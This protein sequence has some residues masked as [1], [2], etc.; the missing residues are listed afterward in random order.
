MRSG[1]DLLYRL[2]GG[3]AAFFLMMIAV[4][5]VAQIVGRAVGVT[6]DS[7]ESGG[8]FLA[9]TTFMGMAYT[10]KTGGHIRVSLLV[11]R[12]SGA[13]ARGADILACGFAA[14]GSA[15]LCWET[16]GMTHDSWR[17]GDLSPGLLAVPI[18]I[19]QS[20]MLAGLVLLTIAL[21][22]DLILLLRGA[23]PGFAAP[24][25]TALDGIEQGE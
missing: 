17:F 8:F 4:T 1:L 10:L 21:I 5:I 24:H 22:D 18:W 2:S 16:Y 14:F 15:Y 19:P 7:T 6:I 13:A 9:G 20:V 25:E 12:L 11:S 3:L 23:I